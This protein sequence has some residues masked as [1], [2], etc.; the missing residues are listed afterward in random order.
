[1]P[2]LI[3]AVVL[4]GILCVLDLILS[5]GVIRRLRIHNELI[6][7]LM[8]GEA[9][10]VAMMMPVGDSAEPFTAIT[11][12]DGMVTEKSL[13]GRNLV[14]FFL[15]DCT[16]CQQLL[17]D[18][19][20]AAARFPGGR[21]RVL[22]VVVHTSGEEKIADYRGRLAPVARVVVEGADQGIGAAMKVRGFP[23]FGLLDDGR[24]LASGPEILRATAPAV[25]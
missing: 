23:A 16:G 22:A 11:D 2:Y 12:A 18:F 3:A 15:E 8:S 6:T 1:M 20:A 5:L 9:T 10:S 4:V 19:L 21:E 7:K 14:G 25:G 17:P 13:P 24:L